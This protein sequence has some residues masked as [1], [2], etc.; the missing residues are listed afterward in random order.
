MTTPE[1]GNKAA[2][3]ESKEGVPLANV[4]LAYRE[5]DMFDW[6]IPMI[7]KLLE[8]EGKTVALRSFPR[9]TSRQ[10]ITAHLEKEGQGLTDLLSS[11]KVVSDITVGTALRNMNLP[12]NAAEA[13][14]NGQG[15]LERPF[16]KAAAGFAKSRITEAGFDASSDGKMSKENTA[17]GVAF[18]IAR[19]KEALGDADGRIVVL[20]DKMADH[21][22]FYLRGEQ[23]RFSASMT[24]NDLA[25]WEREAAEEIAGWAQQAG[26]P[27]GK[28]LTMTLRELQ[29]SG[30]FAGKTFVIADRHN[31]DAEKL[32]MPLLKMPLET[33]I[34]DA[35]QSGA[36]SSEEDLSAFQGDIEKSVRAIFEL[37]E[38]K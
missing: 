5:N 21:E 23:N 24:P 27:A 18:F 7:R 2:S 8:S 9:G 31:Y 37:G 22:P 19:I 32:D 25:V 20:S 1:A 15:L 14:R 17:K 6:G 36:I 33:M 13:V 26:F 29:G 28:T 30:A 3:V 16:K 12:D 38:E 11:S 4:L 10:E 34:T 35:F